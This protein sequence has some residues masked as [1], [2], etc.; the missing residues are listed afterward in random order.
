MVTVAQ[1]KFLGQQG[2][3]R[4]A[5]LGSDNAPQVSPV[6]YAATESSIYITIDQKPKT[7]DT[8]G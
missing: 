1:I 4:L 2:V 6:C 3:A 5:T 8:L 7:G